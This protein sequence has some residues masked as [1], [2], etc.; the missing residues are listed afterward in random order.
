M[1]LCVSQ[2][3]RSL[4]RDSD[5]ELI[6]VTHSKPTRQEKKEFQKEAKAWK[7]EMKQELK[8]MGATNVRFHTSFR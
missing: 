4:Y 3:Q 5:G 6:E 7:A 1:G 2:P 8:A